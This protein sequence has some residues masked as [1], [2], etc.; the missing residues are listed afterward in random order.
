[1][2]REQIIKDIQAKSQQAFA[3]I[4]TQALQEAVRNMSAV[5]ATGDSSSGGGG[6]RYDI[7]FVVNTLDSTYFNFSF[8]SDG[9]PIEFTIY[10]GDGDVYQGSGGGGYYSENHTYPEV[11]D[12][13]VGIKF[14]DPA[15]ILQLDFPGDGDAP[16]KSITGLQNLSN[17]QEFRAD[18]NALESIDFS[19]LTNL[20]YVDISDCNL[21]G[22]STNSLTSVNLSG[23]YNLTDL[24]VDD[25]DF[26]AGFP[27]LIGLVNLTYF[28]ADQSGI[29][30]TL[31]LSYLPA[32]AGFDLS[33]NE[34]LTEVIISDTQSLGGAQSIYLDG[35][36]LTE[37]A[38]D[39]ILIALST[40]GVF[41][42]YI[43]LSGGTNAVPSAAGIAARG[44][45]EGNGWYVQTN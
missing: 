16:I 10:W 39:N 27:N 1:M 43:D 35:C 3:E 44:I 13:I 42:G 28:D 36:A 37:E 40:N 18:W 25:S 30:G 38:V 29:T 6:P 24:R 34:V 31:D 9:N 5:A 21:V 26:S 32:L 19:G 45:L 2:N 22:T 33:G 11:G 8:T 15:K 23:C 7:E 4:R 17:L 12:Y 14:D 41:G 20:T